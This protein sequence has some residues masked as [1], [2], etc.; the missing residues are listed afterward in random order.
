M[1]NNL[2]FTKKQ[3][4]NIKDFV[5]KT[6]RIVDLASS[7]RIL[8]ICNHPKEITK[9]EF[10]G[11]DGKQGYCGIHC[12]AYITV[13]LGASYNIGLIQFLLMDLPEDNNEGAKERKYYF[14]VLVSDYSEDKIIDKDHIEWKVLYDSNGCGYRNW[15]FFRVSDGV[16]ARFVRI[17]CLHNDKNKGFHIVRLR[18]Y[19][20]EI[21]DI[22]DYNKIKQRLI[23]PDNEY[24]I[25][26]KY[27]LSQ[28]IEISNDNIYMEIGDGFPLSKRIY[29]MT[30]LLEQ[31][32]ENEI[33]KGILELNIEDRYLKNIN[34]TVCDILTRS[35]DNDNVN[36]II[37]ISSDDIVQ[38]LSSIG[39][40][41]YVVEN[42]SDGMERIVLDPVNIKLNRSNKGSIF[43]NILSL[44]TLILWVILY[45]LK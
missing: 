6:S 7:K 28:I 1:T 36:K 15:Q 4:I 10:D 24:Y 32:S 13:D 34:K 9:D 30:N 45:F 44:V 2:K 16:K 21:A 12:P 29:D 19:E 42:N 22:I 20:K 18:V 37:H 25:I 26:D 39:D 43:W 31:I 40:D 41:I 3:N 8:E 33:A 38:I 35:D 17:H 11:Y 5:P 14:R 23:T 27:N